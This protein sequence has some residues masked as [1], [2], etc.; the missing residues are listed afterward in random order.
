MTGRTP[1]LIAWGTARS[2]LP[3]GPLRYRMRM[4]SFR[5]AVGVF[6]ILPAPV[7]TLDRATTPKLI[8]KFPLV[9]LLIGTIAGAASLLLG[10]ASMNHILAAALGI[11]ILAACTGAMHLDGLADTADGLGSRKPAEEALAIMRQSDVGPMGVA[12]LVLVLLVQVAALSGLPTGVMAVALAAGPMVGRTSCVRATGFWHPSAR[13]TGF[14]ALFSQVT[15]M[16]T[17]RKITAW[18]LIGTAALGGMSHPYLFQVWPLGSYDPAQFVSETALF[19]AAFLFSGLTALVIGGLITR[20][21]SRR[22]GGLTGDTFGAIVEVSTLAFWL[23]LAST[24]R[25]MIAP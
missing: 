14:G 4:N 19:I 15:P 2:V 23:V 12:A 17:A 24:I 6:T 16:Q 7:T 13:T 8:R 9:G 22:L 5:G 1:G 3:L 25:L 18:A 21:L 10:W 11:G 20:Y